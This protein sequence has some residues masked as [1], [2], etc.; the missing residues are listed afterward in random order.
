MFDMNLLKEDGPL[1]V[2]GVVDEEVGGA[3]EGEQQVAHVGHPRYPHRP[4]RRL[5]VAVSL[6]RWNSGGLT[7]QADKLVHY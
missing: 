3:G 5:G 6:Q 7:V 2:F 1:S 4:R